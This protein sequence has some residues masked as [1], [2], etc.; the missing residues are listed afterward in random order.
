M[1][2]MFGVRE[3]E[4]VARTLVHHQHDHAPVRDLNREADRRLRRG[5]QIAGDLARMVGSWTFVVLQALMTAFWLV[6]NVF[7]ATRHWDP[8]PFLLL[9]LVLSLESTLWASLVLMALTQGVDRER[10]RAQQDYE[11]DVKEEEEV[12]A[13][14]SHLETQDELLLQVLYRLDRTDRELRR[15]AGRLGLSEESAG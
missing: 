15:L 7:A 4:D 5:S 10:L 6:L 11:T 1:P 12:R 2:D 3:V 13:L 9:N 14:M 8:Y